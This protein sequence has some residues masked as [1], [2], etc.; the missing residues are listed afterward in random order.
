MSCG[1]LLKGREAGSTASPG[2]GACRRERGTR[3]S[4]FSL[5]ISSAYSLCLQYDLKIAREASSAEISCL[6]G[7]IVLVLY[8]ECNDVS[9]SAH[10]SCRASEPPASNLS[11]I[12]KPAHQCCLT[13][14]PGGHQRQRGSAPAEWRLSRPNETP[15]DAFFL[16]HPPVFRALVRSWCPARNVFVCKVSLYSRTGMARDQ[17]SCKLCKF[18]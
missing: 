13:L 1:A 9:D 5:E 10:G 6:S 4:R 11:D 18:L 8:P 14:T 2:R 15:P 17:L 7:E 16:F 3:C 12:Q